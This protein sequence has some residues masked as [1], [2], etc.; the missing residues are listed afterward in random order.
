MNEI[1]KPG[2]EKLRE[3]LFAAL[4][5]LKD[6][7][8]D[9]ARAKAMSDISQTIINSAKVEIDFQSQTK[10]LVRSDFFPAPEALEAPK[11]GTTNTQHGYLELNGS[12]TVHRMK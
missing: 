9:V 12:S 5:G 2:I 7:T 11:T 3:S 1:T 10:R 6:G 8:I 4:D